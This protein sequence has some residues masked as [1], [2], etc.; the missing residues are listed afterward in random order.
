MLRLS[1]ALLLSFG[2]VC[3]QSFEVASVKPSPPGAYG[4]QIHGGPGSTDPGTAS[5]SNI[6]LASLIIMAYDVNSYQ[7]AGP[8][9]LRN[10]RFEIV[11]KVPPGTTIPQYRV[12]LQICWPSVSSWPSTAPEGG[13][14]FRFNCGEEWPETEGIQHPGD[15]R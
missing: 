10:S 5:F 14:G 9:W 2:L 4:L 15:A 3:G 11:A 1:A 13:P 7:L 12:M 8:D 6:D